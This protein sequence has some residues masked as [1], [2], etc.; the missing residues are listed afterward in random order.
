MPE[1]GPSCQVKARPDLEWR[2]DKYVILLEVDE[3]QHNREIFRQSSG[4]EPKVSDEPGTSTSHSQYT[5]DC[6]LTRMINLHATYRVPTIFIRYNPDSW[7]DNAKVKHYAG[8]ISRDIG[9]LDYITSIMQEF[10]KNPPEDGLYVAYFYYDGCK[11]GTKETCIP[12]KYKVDYVNM[13][14]SSW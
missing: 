4:S 3:K 5:C 1:E 14:R 2:R 7:T 9:V 8:Q 6:E 10:D 11:K 12:D 13:V